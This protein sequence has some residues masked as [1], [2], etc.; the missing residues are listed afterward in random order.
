[1]LTSAGAVS[2]WSANLLT[3]FF[4]LRPR[5]EREK[6]LCFSEVTL[7][8]VNEMGKRKNRIKI[9]R[10]WKLTVCY[11]SAAPEGY[12]IKAQHYSGQGEA[13]RV[14]NKLYW[15]AKENVFWCMLYRPNGSLAEHWSRDDTPIEPQD[16]S[17]TPVRN[18]SSRIAGYIPDGEGLPERSKRDALRS[19]GGASNA[20]RSVGVFRRRSADTE[21]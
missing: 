21:A 13:K 5:G 16:E 4:V 7:R 9:L 6:R 2:F 3:L 17:P 10:R 12:T 14:M 18:L 20:Y 1:M 19:T 8:C 11:K 15:K